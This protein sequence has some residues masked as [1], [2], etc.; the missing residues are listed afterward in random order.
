MEEERVYHFE[1]GSVWVEHVD[2]QAPAEDAAGARSR[3]PSLAALLKEAGIASEEGIRG[4]LEE[5]TRRG[6]KLGEVVVRRGWATEDQLAELLAKQWQLPFVPADALSVDPVAV[7]RLPVA[8]ARELAGLPLWFENQAI[9]VAIA[10]PNED[11]FAAFRELLG[12]VSFVVVAR[13]TL[14]RL[15]P[16]SPATR[17]AAPETSPRPVDLLGTWMSSAPASDASEDDLGATV[18]AGGELEAGESTSD[19][20]RSIHAEVQGLEK[21][22][23]E[24]L[25]AA[26]EQQKELD[27]A[28]EARGRDAETIRRLEAKLGEHGD[29]FSALKDKVEELRHAF[30]SR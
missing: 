11:R 8:E 16:S 23:Q 26:A 19:R 29:L 30:E 5:G 4:A 12:D 22:L 18:A 14:E 1:D 21:A 24:A 28:R 6:E 20:L 15:L 10:E 7:S 27:A 9:V 3:R 13:S 25:Q 17:S 2:E